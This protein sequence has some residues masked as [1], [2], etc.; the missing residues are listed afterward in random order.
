M[1]ECDINE[2]LRTVLVERVRVAASR[3]SL[4]LD[5]PARHPGLFHG[6]SGRVLALV[7]MSRAI[8]LSLDR[9]RLAS[10]LAEVE[11]P[12]LADPALMTGDVGA[13][14]AQLVVAGLADPPVALAL[15]PHRFEVRVLDGDTE[16]AKCSG[17]LVREVSRTERGGF[18][19]R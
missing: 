6:T 10:I 13:L 2:T 4:D 14:L 12:P 17:E 18:E 19:T 7:I 3:T 15:L 9:M 1:L 8:G 5:S 16:T 11:V